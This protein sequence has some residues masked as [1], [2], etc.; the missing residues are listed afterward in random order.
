MKLYGD[1]SGYIINQQSSSNIFCAHALEEAKIA[2]KTALGIDQEDGEGS[3]L[4]LPECFML[5]KRH[6]LSFLREKLQSRFKRWFAKSLSQGGKEI[7]LKSIGLT[8][9]IYAMSCFKLLKDTCERLASAM[10]EF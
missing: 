9:P 2:V 10:I 7:L 4:D 1:A 5:S 3:Y 6:L 8:L